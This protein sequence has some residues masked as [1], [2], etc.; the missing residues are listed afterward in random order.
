MLSR[1][2]NLQEDL[3]EGLEIMSGVSDTHMCGLPLL[4]EEESAF[5]Y[6]LGE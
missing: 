6:G 4:P 5:A 1:G 2:S 3:Q